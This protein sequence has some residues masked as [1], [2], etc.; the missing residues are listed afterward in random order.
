MTASELPTVVIPPK[1]I[2]ELKKL[3]DTVLGFQEAT[4]EVGGLLHARSSQAPDR[5]WVV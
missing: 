1:F 4:D 3:S 5:T 2:P